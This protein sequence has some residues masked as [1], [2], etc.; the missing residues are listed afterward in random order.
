MVIILKLLCKY[1]PSFIRGDIDFLSHLPERTN[2]DSILVSFDV[3]GRYTNIP[4]DLG[5]EA[6]RYW[7][8]KHTEAIPERFIDYFILEYIQLI[9]ENN[10]FFFE[11][12]HYVQIKGTAMGTKF[13]PTY[14]TLVMGYLEQ[15]LYKKYLI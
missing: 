15:K 8:G 4:H 12:K 2:S 14:A 1:V 3:T 11:G 13:A 6:V 7:I 9:L 5:I 10:S